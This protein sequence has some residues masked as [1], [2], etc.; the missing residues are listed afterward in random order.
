MGNTKMKLV[1]LLVIFFQMISLILSKR[2]NWNLF[3]KIG[4]GIKKG[5]DGYE[6]IQKVIDNPN[7]APGAKTDAEKNAEEK[8][9]KKDEDAFNLNGVVKN[10][11]KAQDVTNILGNALGKFLGGR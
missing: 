3:K 5:L 8:K 6:Q 4:E 1:Y 11:Q 9:K 2:E 7:P 10:V